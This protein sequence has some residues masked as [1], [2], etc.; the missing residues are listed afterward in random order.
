MKIYNTPTGE[1]LKILKKYAKAM[2]DIK[3]SE[4]A[5]YAGNTY[6][7]VIFKNKALTKFVTGKTFF[8]Y[9]DSKNNVITDKTTILRL[10]RLFFFMDAYLNDGDGSIIGALQNED[11]VQKNKDDLELMMD[12]LKIVEGRKEKYDVTSKDIAETEKILLKIMELRSKTNEK[13]N[14]FLKNVESE[15]KNRKYFD[16]NIIEACMPAYKE[17]MV[18]NFEKVQLIAK[19]GNMYNAIKKAAEKSRKSYGIRFSMKQ[20]DALLK[21]SYMMGYFENLLR[22]YNSILSMSINQYVKNIASAGKTNAEY[23]LEQIRK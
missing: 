14:D 18:C 2:E 20:T 16:E 8:L 1:E 4:P 9:L 7:E 23:K 19:G 11:A 15:M 17:V 6:R 12:G 21:L 10:G 22:S 13:L 5:E 3:I